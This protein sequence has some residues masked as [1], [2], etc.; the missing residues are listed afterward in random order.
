MYKIDR[1]NNRLIALETTQFSALKFQERAHLQEWIAEE[2]SVLGEE[3]LIIQKEF[4]GFN[5][6]RERLDLLAL[7]KAGTLVI[8]E[9]KLDD[10]GRD[11][12]WQ[13]MKYASYCSQ[14]SKSDIV[15][16]YQEYL[17]SQGID[18]TAEDRILEFLQ[19]EEFGELQ[20]NQGSTQRIILIAAN[21]RK[22]VTSTVLWLL[23]FRL[24]IQCMRVS[25]HTD[26]PEAYLH[27]EQIIPTQ[28]AEEYMISMAEKAQDDLESQSKQNALQRLRRDFW[29]QLLVEMRKAPTDLYNSISPGT[30]GHISASSGIP[31]LGFNFVVSNSYARSELYISNQDPRFNLRIFDALISQ[32]SEI[33]KAFGASLE[34]ERLDGK[35]ACRIKAEAPGNVSDR[36]QWGTMIEFMVNAMVRLEKA[37]KKP[38]QDAAGIASKG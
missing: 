35:K 2:P 14:L 1:Q 37:L 17:S 10:S 20:L 25:L 4:A 26:G 27:F 32:K 21:F 11:V 33:E 9:N 28:D 19:K 30:A 12:T 7:D 5:D 3:L 31:G 16:I 22:E 36:E 34:W 8:I 38:L 29:S 18:A 6:T 15:K 13:A 24:Q 23:N